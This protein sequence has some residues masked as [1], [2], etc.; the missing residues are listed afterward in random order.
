MTMRRKTMNVMKHTLSSVLGGLVVT[1]VTRKLSNTPPTLL[2]ATQ[3]GHPFAWLIRLQIPSQY[4]PWRIDPLNFLADVAVW[5]V[6]VGIAVFL[7]QKAK[8]SSRKKQ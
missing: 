2:A 4:F 7:V 5:S 8:K 6:I 3:Y 1:L